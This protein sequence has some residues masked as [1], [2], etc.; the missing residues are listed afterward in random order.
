LLDCAHTRDATTAKAVLTK[1]VQDC[2]SYTLERA[3][4][5]LFGAAPSRRRAGLALTAAV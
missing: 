3:P 4:P 5:R 1:H 2:V